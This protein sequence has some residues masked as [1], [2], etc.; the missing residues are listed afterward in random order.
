MRKRPVARQGEQ[1]Y[2]NLF[3]FVGLRHLQLRPGRTI[4][5]TLGVAFGIA[6][7]VAIAIINES[8]KNALKESIEAVAGKSN[9]TVSAGVA[10]VSCNASQAC[11]AS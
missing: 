5:T 9:L 11:T 4:L 8:T 1:L 10:T 3:K 7:Y 2:L 6:L